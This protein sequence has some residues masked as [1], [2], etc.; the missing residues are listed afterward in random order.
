MELESDEGSVQFEKHF[1][2]DNSLDEADQSSQSDFE[3]F[4]RAEASD[5]VSLM[6][7]S[8]IEEEQAAQK[9]SDNESLGDASMS[10]AD[11]LLTTQATSIHSKACT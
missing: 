10:S 5:D 6:S 11:E 8:S 7:A 9:E 1:S 3:D 4:N 2:T